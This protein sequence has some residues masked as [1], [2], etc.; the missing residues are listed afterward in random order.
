MYKLLATTILSFLMIVFFTNFAIAAEWRVTKVTG[1]A[2]ITSQSHP[3]KWVRIGDF[4]KAGDYLKTMTNSTVAL[5]RNAEA[6]IVSANSNIEIPK[7]GNTNSLTLIFQRLGT[8]LFS[9]KKKNRKHFEIRTAYA[10]ALVKGT[11]FVVNVNY[12]NSQIQVFEGSVE[13]RGK[14]RAKKYI[15]NAGVKSLIPHNKTQRILVRKVKNKSRI[16]PHLGSD[17]NKLAETYINKIEIGQNATNRF[18]INTITRDV[19]NKIKISPHNVKPKKVENADYGPTLKK[20][21]P[22]KAV[23]DKQN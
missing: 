3:P 1:K 8:V 23:K 20:Y 16:N 22:R 9:A 15:L 19:F 21:D 7:Q 13:L 10:V 2:I 17:I 14:A 18:N 12:R 6:M 11:T 5:V 4:L